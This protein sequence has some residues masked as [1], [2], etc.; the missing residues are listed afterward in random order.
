LLLDDDEIN[1]KVKA[2][3]S[4]SDLQSDGDSNL[5]HK[6]NQ[7]KAK[8]K[9]KLKTQNNE[10]CSEDDDSKTAEFFDDDSLCK[11]LKLE[12]DESSNNTSN[13]EGFVDIE[14]DTLE[15]SNASSFANGKVLEASR[16]T[17][18]I[19]DFLGEKIGPKR[20][21][22]GTGG[23]RGRP[24]TSNKSSPLRGTANS[25]GDESNLNSKLQYKGPVRPRAF[26]LI[27]GPMN[28][29]DRLHQ[30]SSTHKQVQQKSIAKVTSQSSF[31]GDKPRL[32]FKKVLSPS[33]S[34]Q[35][36]LNPSP[37]L[38]PSYLNMSPQPTNNDG[39]ENS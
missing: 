30:V 33:S 35:S 4:R 37:S 38:T 23:K 1:R 20:P 11:R 18:P 10:E 34:S 32:S 39:H 7:K 5:S 36:S 2:K 27:N 17:S 15:H 24:P 16:S 3:V 12:Q 21:K 26:K 22:R 25:S 31:L 9:R 13:T 14:G 19:F 6:S 28:Q 8:S 29:G